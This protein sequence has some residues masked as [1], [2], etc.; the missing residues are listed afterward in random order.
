MAHV[1]FTST[2]T[3]RQ[4]VIQLGEQPD[5]VFNYGAPGLENIDRLT[6]LELEELETII[7]VKLGDRN[8]L[9][10][11]HPVTLE[12]GTTTRSFQALLN[13]LDELSDTKVIFTKANADTDGR[14]INRMI[15]EYVAGRP[16]EAV[17][18]ISLGQLHY[19]S[20]LK[21][22]DGVVGNSSS[23]I[24]EAQSLHVGTVNIGSRQ[25]GRVRADSVIDCEATEESLGRAFETLFSSEFQATLPSTIN[26]HGGGH[27]AAKIV[28]ILR[29][30]S[31]ENV[32]KK[33][34]FD[35]I[36]E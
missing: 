1:H 14:A 7:E 23:G 17:S 30:Q 15:D 3:Y 22:V 25:N 6:L 31:L 35:L 16:D 36:I 32:I 34:F 29:E 20:V 27:V 28:R 11:L 8:L 5:R 10:T 33:P 2:E 4:R 21:Y 13:A 12:P 18:H 19:L 24:I 26:P 9:V